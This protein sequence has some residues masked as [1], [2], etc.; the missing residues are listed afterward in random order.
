MTSI[1][2]RFTEEANPLTSSIDLL[3]PLG[4]VENI[5]K[6]DAELFRGHAGLPGLASQL[7]KQSIR[8]AILSVVQCLRVPQ[9]K[10]LLVGC[11]TS[12][13]I[14]HWTAREMNQYYNKL[15][16]KILDSFHYL[17]AGGDVALLLPQESAEDQIARA[18]QDLL[19]WE[20]SVSLETGAPV[21]IFGISCGFSANYVSAIASVLLH[22]P[23]KFRGKYRVH[24]IGFNPLE[25]VKSFSAEDESHSFPSL[26]TSI[27]SSYPE[28]FGIINPIIGPEAIA[29]SSR[30]KGGT[31]TKII[32]DIIMY[33][34]FES[35]VH[36]PSNGV[37]ICFFDEY[38]DYMLN[39]YQEAIARTYSQAKVLADIMSSVG[40]SLNFADSS[41]SSTANSVSDYN[42]TGRLFYLG[43]GSAGCLALL[44]AS[45]C[46]PTFGSSFEDVRAFVS[47]GWQTL[48][49]MDGPLAQQVPSRLLRRQDRLFS[50]CDSPNHQLLDIELSNFNSTLVNSIS[51]KDT[52]VV[53]Y[54]EDESISDN[55]VIELR[56]SLELLPPCKLFAVLVLDEKSVSDST[57]TAKVVA[58]IMQYVQQDR[59]CQVTLPSLIFNYAS[60]MQ[61]ND[62]NNPKT[63]PIFGEIAMKLSLNVISTGAHI[64]RGR[65]FENRMAN[66]QVSNVKLLHRAVGIIRSVTGASSALAQLS[67]LRAIYGFNIMFPTQNPDPSLSK[68]PLNTILPVLVELDTDPVNETV[69]VNAFRCEVRDFLQV[70]LNPISQLLLTLG[71]DNGMESAFPATHHVSACVGQRN[72]VP[73]SILLAHD[74]VRK[75]V[76]LSLHSGELENLDTTVTKNFHLLKIAQARVILRH[77]PVVRKAL[78]QLNSIQFV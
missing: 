60:P 38:M 32:L 14:A 77:E 24:L 1:N 34:S 23:E 27:L 70:S 43:A 48:R 31:M 21:T 30:M 76:A 72:V 54:I 74:A 71:S 59:I 65:I 11:G 4:I 67:L 33:Y 63:A 50:D 19:D 35:I 42:K 55:D 15:T 56:K 25:S 45:E 36:V 22:C 12:G 53:T 28:N 57:T 26:I 49:N 2:R 47:S 41:I 17:I 37:A 64:L 51:Q 18:V 73:L 8:S 9:G 75:N 5:A 68:S 13:R 6:V 20:S 44:D 69:N 62:S 39:N 58:A 40:E 29:G 61:K 66:V 52:V 7:V 3:C 46:I 10:V 16:T 78:Q